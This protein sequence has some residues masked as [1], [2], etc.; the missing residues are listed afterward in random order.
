MLGVL[1]HGTV[2]VQFQV[3]MREVFV[4]IDE[5]QDI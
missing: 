2:V 5:Y 3:V 1:V 4:S